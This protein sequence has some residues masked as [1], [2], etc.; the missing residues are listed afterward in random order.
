VNYNTY[1]DVLAARHGQLEEAQRVLRVMEEREV[2]PDAITYTN[3]LRVLGQ[4]EQVEEM[5]GVLR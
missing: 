1:L 4:H 2:R 5:Q 3:Y